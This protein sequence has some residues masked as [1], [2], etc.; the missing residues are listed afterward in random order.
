MARAAM[1]A[2]TMAVAGQLCVAPGIVSAE[3]TR[4]DETAMTA[5]TDA[6]ADGH[7]VQF[8]DGTTLEQAQAVLDAS[9]VTVR[10][11]YDDVFVGALVDGD[12]EQLA[13]LAADPLVVDVE[14]NTIV[15]VPT[16]TGSAA[17]TRTEMGEQ[18]AQVS[19]SWAL[20]RL[21]QRQ[22]A[23][24][25]GFDVPLT[26]AGVTAYVLDS[27]V[28]A[29]HVEFSGRVLPGA[30]AND[31]L[32]PTDCRGH[33]THVAG[34]IGGERY[35]VAKDVSIVPVRVLDCNGMTSV[36]TFLNGL[37]WIVAHHQPGVPAVLNM[38]LGGAANSLVDAAVET[39]IADGIVVVAAAGNEGEPACWGSPAR[40]PG[41]ITVAATDIT[42]WSPNWS[43]YGSCVDIFAPGQQ[44]TSSWNTTDTA[45]RTI[46]G[47]SMAAP[48]V[49]GAVA[50]ILQ[51]SPT[52][53]PAQVT[54]QLLSDATVG[55]VRNG[56]S[57]S[58]NRLLFVPSR[59]FVPLSPARLMDSRF[60]QSTIDGQ[61]QGM[62]VRAGGTVTELQVGG[63]GGVP[64]DASA[65]VLN[66]TVT[67]P[68]AAGFV[69]VFPCGTTVPNGSN[70]NFWAGATIPNAVVAK[71]GANGRVCLYSNVSTHLLVD[72]NGFYPAGSSFVP[73]SP[74][75]L[76]DS[77]AGQV[78]IDGQAAGIGVRAGGTVTEFQIGG[79]GGVPADASAV[80]LN[81]TV[82]EPSAAGFVTVFPCGTAVPN[83]SNL[84]FWTGATIPNA[85]VA[86]TGAN[87]RV[88]LYSNVSTHLLVDV[89]GYYPMGSSFVPLAP[90]RL[91]DTRPGNS[92]IDGL[93]SGAGIRLGGYFSELQV[94]GRGGVPSG[95]A[96]V[97]LN[98]TVT[99]ASAG[100]FLT[101]YP[102]G[103]PIPNGSNLNFWPGATIPNAVVA[104]I[105]DG[106]RVCFYSSASTHLIVDVNGFQ[107]A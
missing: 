25:G 16:P 43:N 47:T 50:L 9:G 59:T 99:Q 67:E 51:A 15:K 34:L 96:A 64:A 95:A 63:R 91:A 78:T 65:V 83:G 5:T 6:P 68:S 106:G 56:G 28:R 94:T 52:W 13:A 22:A 24:N 88:C 2:V 77:R 93:A 23:L 72:A 10:E 69:T 4:P 89:N 75:R 14:A 36:A 39:A 86:K 11:R 70:L 32:G 37:D 49:S 26:G 104:K 71:A 19:S 20:D 41:A 45:I 76:M 74:A 105:G 46:D 35:G 21:D 38:S 79:R 8:V 29:D 92:T 53:S 103:T 61:F 80:V 66:V 31:G 30:Y 18:A 1:L 81:V 33:G 85:V 54:A 82:T 100:G 17:P 3:D 58:P 87:G 101:V 73:L 97:V 57:L 98:V 44:V 40:V 12:A 107:S 55:L 62:G 27:G 42:D 60:G 102:C 7:V 48:L 90:A 84:N